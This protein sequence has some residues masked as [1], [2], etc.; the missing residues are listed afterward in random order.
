LKDDELS[1]T[2]TPSVILI[3]VRRYFLKQIQLVMLFSLLHFF[4]YRKDNGSTDLERTNSI[5]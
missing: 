1:I 3:L 4:E 2:S 5:A